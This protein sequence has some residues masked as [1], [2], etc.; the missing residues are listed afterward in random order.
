MGGT[1]TDKGLVLIYGA[2]TQDGF[3]TKNGKLFM[4]FSHS[5]TRQRHLGLEH[6]NF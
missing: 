5:F 4:H 1:L 6:A 3:L 2:L